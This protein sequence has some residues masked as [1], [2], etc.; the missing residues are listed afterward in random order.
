[1]VKEA[2]MAIDFYSKEDPLLLLDNLKH[3][4]LEDKQVELADELN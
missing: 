3:D 2:V 4:E 1:M